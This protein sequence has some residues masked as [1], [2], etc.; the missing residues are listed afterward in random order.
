MTKPNGIV[1]KNPL[2]EFTEHHVK[3]KFSTEFDERPIHLNFIDLSVYHGVLLR[4][5]ASNFGPLP[6]T[7][8][9]HFFS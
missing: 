6:L 8:H 1:K 9:H 5:G 2:K 7:F 3:L 4:A